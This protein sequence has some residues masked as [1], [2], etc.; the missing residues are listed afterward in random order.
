MLERSREFIELAMRLNYTAAA[1][2]LHLST[3]ALSRHIADLEAELGFALFNRTPLSLTQAGQY[4]LESISSLID[5]LDAIVARGREIDALSSRPFNIYM[6]PTRAPFARAVYEASAALR[7]TYAGLSTSVCADDRFLTTEEALLAGK[8]DVG[9]MYQGVIRNADAI[10]TEVF[11]YAP[12][13]AYVHRCNP[14][15]SREAIELADL[16]DYL[17]PKSI[18]RQSL[19][20]TD[21]VEALFRSAGVRLKLRL[22]NIQSL[23]EFFLSLKEDEFFIEF[24]EG[25]DDEG[26][27]INPDLVRL[28][29]CE[30]IW[31]PVYVAY[32]R[33]TTN[34]LVREFAACCH[35][36]AEKRG[37]SSPQGTPEPQ[38]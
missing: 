23:A 21:S 22:R 28:G 37:I 8:A 30:P 2:K 16:S 24:D 19:D 12:I 10:A 6:L 7:R 29:F 33:E 15:A 31:C 11:A 25:E 35:R 18:N 20:G 26:T 1:E 14:L 36:E 17:H 27:R 32:P 38:A 13:C 9:I 34:P 3:S 5:D 4:F